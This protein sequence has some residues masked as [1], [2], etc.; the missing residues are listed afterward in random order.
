ML[1]SISRYF[2]DAVEWTR[3][4]G[5]M[6]LW[7]KLPGNLVALDLF[8]RAVEEKVVFVPGDPFY[9]NKKNTPDFRLNFSCVDT[10]TIEI[11]I[12]RLGGAME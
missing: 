11:G 6:F 7:G 3:P 12:K 4:E 5:G 8:H 1:E 10:A 9:V 2:P